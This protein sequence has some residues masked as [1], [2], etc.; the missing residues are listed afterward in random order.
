[1]DDEIVKAKATAARTWIGHANV[2]AKSYGGK[3][4]RYLLVPHDGLL[5][6]MSLA[7]LVGRHELPPM[8][9]SSTNS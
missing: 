4:W 6:S 5:E 8:V 7:G 9:D 3:S 1:M 2:H